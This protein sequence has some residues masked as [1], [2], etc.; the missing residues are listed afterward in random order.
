MQIFG[1]AI[2]EKCFHLTELGTSFAN[3]LLDSNDKEDQKQQHQQQ[4]EEQEKKD[5][6]YQE[7]K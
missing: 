1:A 7:K 5:F 4:K 3:K 2:A 6:E